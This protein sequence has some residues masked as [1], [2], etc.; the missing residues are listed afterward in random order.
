MQAYTEWEHVFKLDPAKELSDEDLEAV[1]E[2]GTDAV[3]V[4]G[5][6]DV[7]LDNT[8]S[9]LARIRRYSVACTLEV[10]NLESIT[11]GFDYFFIPTVLNAED[12]R[13]ITGL[14]RQALK[15]FGPIMNA[16]EIITE[17]Y[18]IL[19]SESKAAKL[20]NA[21]TNLDKDDVEAAAMLADTLFHLP[22]FYLEYSGMYGDKE[23]VK[24]AKLTLQHAQ[25]FYGGGIETPEQAEE[26]AAYADTVVVGNVVYTDIK[27]ALQTVDA[28]KNNG[29]N[30]RKNV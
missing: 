2:S 11:P 21:D 9:L 29:R 12:S 16:D 20:T 4:G 1:C 5:S 30:S 23:F 26:M 3:I 15:E 24:A 18:C 25:L 10:S 8:L 17:G 22:I 6:D 14:H 27:K 13:W 28:V 19:N 7:T